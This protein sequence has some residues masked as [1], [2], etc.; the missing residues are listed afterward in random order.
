MI[1]HNIKESH[2]ID[3]IVTAKLFNKCVQEDWD[4]IPR[5]YEPKIWQ[6]FLRRNDIELYLDVNCGNFNPTRE[7]LLKRAEIIEEIAFASLQDILQFKA[8]Y[9]TPKHTKDIEKIEEYLKTPSFNIQ[10]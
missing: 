6:K 5:T 2:D 4:Q 7:E 10:H 3:I 8:A 9:N 1:A